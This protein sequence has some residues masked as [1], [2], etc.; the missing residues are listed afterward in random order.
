MVYTCIHLYECS[1]RRLSSLK[2]N[3]NHG[4]AHLRKCNF[5]SEKAGTFIYFFTRVIVTKHDG[6]RHL[7]S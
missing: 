2:V 4:V 6:L 1:L 5:L 7:H 3:Y